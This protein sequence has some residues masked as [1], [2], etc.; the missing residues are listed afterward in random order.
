MA[1][2][3]NASIAHFL[4]PSIIPGGELDHRALNAATRCAVLLRLS[5]N[6]V[7]ISIFEIFRTVNS[8]FLLHMSLSPN[9]HSF[10]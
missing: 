6:K 10:L 3:R 4:F 5:A 7:Y 2:G 1:E 8:I 9:L